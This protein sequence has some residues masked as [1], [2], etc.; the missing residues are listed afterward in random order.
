MVV[1]V[2]RCFRHRWFQYSNSR[3]GITN[4]Y[5]DWFLTAQIGFFL[6]LGFPKRGGGEAARAIDWWKLIRALVSQK[7]WEKKERLRLYAADGKKKHSVWH[8]FKLSTL[9][10][11]NKQNVRPPWSCN[12]IS[13]DM[14]NRLK[15]RLSQAKTESWRGGWE[16]VQTVE[17]NNLVNV[18]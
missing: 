3:D 7:R 4:T 2:L 16:H 18:A 17:Y 6:L 12:V 11:A 14:A 8:E 15:E 1:Q 13:V 5:L 9:R 10:H